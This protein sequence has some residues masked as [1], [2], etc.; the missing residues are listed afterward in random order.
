MM[1]HAEM[2][3]CSRILEVVHKREIGL[4]FVTS[5]LLPDLCTGI[6]LANFHSAGISPDVKDLLNKTHRYL[7]H[8]S[9]CLV[10]KV[11]GIPSGPVAFLGSILRR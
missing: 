1:I 9:A 3:K 6:T 5:V 2:F 8:H 11:L 7:L 4:Y 10:R